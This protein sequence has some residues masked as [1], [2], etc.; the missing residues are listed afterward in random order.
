MRKIRSLRQAAIEIKEKDPQTAIG[1]TTL[2]RWAK[3][4]VIRTIRDS[5]TI[6]VDM[7]ELEAFLRGEK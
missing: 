7:E 5:R 3:A 6:Y 1:Y 2:Q 4:G